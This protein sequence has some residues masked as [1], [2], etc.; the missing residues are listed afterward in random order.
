MPGPCQPLVLTTCPA[1]SSGRLLLP[2]S[3]AASP[4][5]AAD[6]Q[7]VFS[8]IYVRAYLCPLLKTIPFVSAVNE[9]VYHPAAGGL[10]PEMSFAPVLIRQKSF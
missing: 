10:L 4:R 6:L 3:L 1:W 5:S 2:T 9:T 8:L 7:L